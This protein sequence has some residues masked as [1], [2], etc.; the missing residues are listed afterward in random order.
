MTSKSKR[1][2]HPSAILRSALDENLKKLPALAL[3]KVIAPKLKSAG[4]RQYKKV[5]GELAEHIANKRSEPFQWGSGAATKDVVIS[6]DD[7]DTAQLERITQNTIE[8]LPDIIERLSREMSR[9][10]VERYVSEWKQSRYLE[11]R[12]IRFFRDDLERLWGASLDAL[13]ILLLACEQGCQLAAE[14]HNNSKA[15]KGRATKSVLIRLHARACQVSSEIITLLE[16]GYAD[17]AIARWRTLHEISIVAL[18]ISDG[19]DDLARAYIEHEIIEIKRAHDRYMIDHETL[20]LS[21]PT[22]RE[23]ARIDRQY[24]LAVQKYGSSFGTEYGWAASYLKLKRP[25]FIDLQDIAK[26]IEMHSYYKMASYNVHAS[27]RGLTHRMT[28]GLNN[29][30]LI[31]GYSNAG[32]EEPGVQ[33][34]MSLTLITS[35][36][37]DY[38]RSAIDQAVYLQALMTMRDEA[39]ARFNEAA[40]SP[41]N[42]NKMIRDAERSL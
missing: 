31:T 17:G 39:L 21:A 18:V 7:S 20:G 10:M 15:R 30:G 27:S 28:D 24:H 14:R 25:R 9:M 11:E 32:L 23:T 12:D 41:R 29:E 4:V 36:A 3:A 22:K 34:A 40:I 35:A 38:G 5:A 33:T 6:F 8:K 19:G 2:Q 16:N 13:R 37:V 1:L 26:R 42:F